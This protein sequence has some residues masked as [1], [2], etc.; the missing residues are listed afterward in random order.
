MTDLLNGHIVVDGQ[1]VSAKIE[2]LVRAIKDYDED[3]QVKWIPVMSRKE[4]DPA[5]CVTYEPEG[6][7]PFILFYVNTEE[8]FDERVLARIIQNDQRHRPTNLTDYEAWEETQ[9]VLQNREWL[10]TMAEAADLA[11]HVFK[12]PL[13]T[14]KVNN[15]LIIKE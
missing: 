12:S 9:K 10:D 8:E 1:F 2:Q 11:W 5:F 7:S 13:H 3:L 15:D 14:Y 6:K 4:G